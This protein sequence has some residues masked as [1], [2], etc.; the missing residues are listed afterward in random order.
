MQ[1][2]VIEFA[3]SIAGLDGAHS[4][5]FN[6]KTPHPVIAL[7]TEW[8]TEEGTLE[9]RRQQSEK[10]GSMRLGGQTCHLMKGTKVRELYGDEVIRERHRHRYEFNNQYMSML[11]QTG[12]VFS[13]VS[14]DGNLVE[15]VENSLVLSVPRG[16]IP[17]GKK[18]TKFQELCH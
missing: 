13:G 16:V 14:A 15:V 2:A 4:T 17:K 3:R 9:Q 11:R 6:A 5:E 12:L 18:K 10:G 8:M 1:V 7:I